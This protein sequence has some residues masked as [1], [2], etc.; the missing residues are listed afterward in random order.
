MGHAREQTER[1][2]E[3]LKQIRKDL[4][5]SQGGMVKFLNLEDKLTREDISKFER[6]IRE[7]SLRTILKY[8][9]SIGISTDVLIDDEQNLPPMVSKKD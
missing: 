1:L 2:A 7:P 6:A 9:R 4:K 8:A 5:L 3:K